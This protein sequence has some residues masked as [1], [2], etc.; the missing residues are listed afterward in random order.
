MRPPFQPFVPTSLPVKIGLSGTGYIATGLL[1]ALRHRCGYEV[2]KVLSR[3]EGQPTGMDAA[4]VTRSIEDLVAAADVVVDCSGHVRRTAELVAAAHAA[5][6][7]VVTLGTEFHVTVGSY[8]V[9]TGYLTEAEGDQPGCLAALREEAVQLG[10]EPLVY[11][12]IKGYLNKTPVESEMLKWS[13]I[14]GISVAQ[15]TSFTD[16]TKLQMEQAFAANGLGARV[17]RQGL[18]GVREEE[19]SEAERAAGERQLDL[20]RVFGARL[21]AEADA[22]GHAIADYV[23]CNKLPAGVFVVG[24]HPFA[25]QGVL[26]YLKM[27]EGPYYTVVK[28]YHLCHLEMLKTL[29]RV[30]AGGAPLLNNSERPEVMVLAIAKRALKKDYWMERGAGSFDVR[31]EAA[32]IGENPDAVPLGLLD[33]VRV[34]RDLEPGEVLSWA[35]VE[36]PAGLMLEA[37]QAL[38]Y[39]G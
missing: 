12:N 16:G 25:E 11:G 30:V 32:M 26:R 31:G 6:K 7:P 37:A 14:N 10:F 18:I 4:L 29:D 13:G 24:R 33:G 9:G 3:R 38:R 28:N 1:G 21:G 5:G 39:L 20:L 27:G 35:D 36:I 19:L 23:L 15:T 2:V 22:V 17:A 34:L 8:F